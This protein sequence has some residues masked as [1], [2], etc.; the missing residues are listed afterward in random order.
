ME[1][2]TLPS[3]VDKVRFKSMADAAIEE[4]NKTGDVYEFQQALSKTIQDAPSFASIAIK[5][6]ISS[7]LD[8]G[9]QRRNQAAEALKA[10]A[11]P[12]TNVTKE[13]FIQGFTLVLESAVDLEASAV[14]LLFL[15]AAV[16]NR[17]NLYWLALLRL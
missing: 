13:Q 2:S 17:A 10:L 11:G 15:P 3:L 6:L 5:R 16:W 14:C 7:S 12:P 4:L 1:P 8:G 9:E